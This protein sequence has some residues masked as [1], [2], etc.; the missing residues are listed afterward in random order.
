MIDGT[1]VSIVLMISFNLAKQIQRYAK[2]D[3]NHFWM[4]D[5]FTTLQSQETSYKRPPKAMEE[6]LLAKPTPGVYIDK[7]GEWMLLYESNAYPT[8]EELA[9]PELR[10]AGLRIN[11]SN[12]GPSRLTWYSQKLSQNISSGALHITGLP[13]D[14]AASNINWS[15]QMTK[16]C[17]ILA[18]LR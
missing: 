5:L 4:P 6:M 2:V 10:I 18:Q 11:P 9:R 1:I 12:F 8:I 14:L 13:Q 17:W 7:K 15:P 3:T 16:N